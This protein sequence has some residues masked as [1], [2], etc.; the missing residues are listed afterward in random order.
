METQ[1][2]LFVQPIHFVRSH[3]CYG[4]SVLIRVTDDHHGLVTEA[5]HCDHEACGGY[6]VAV[7]FERIRGKR[8]SLPEGFTW[9]TAQAIVRDDPRYKIRTAVTPFCLKEEEK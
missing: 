2:L 9:D 1:A 3:R 8:V 4:A 6:R 5:S 7:D